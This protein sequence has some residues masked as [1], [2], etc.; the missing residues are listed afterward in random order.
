MNWKW[1]LQFWCGGGM[2]TIQHLSTFIGISVHKMKRDTV[3]FII[4]FSLTSQSADIYHLVAG[5]KWMSYYFAIFEV[6]YQE[7][8]REKS[9]FDPSQKSW[10]SIICS[11]IAIYYLHMRKKLWNQCS[12][13]RIP[14][15]LLH[16]YFIDSVNTDWC[17]KCVCV[18]ARCNIYSM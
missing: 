8:I 3:Q 6:I 16:L 9:E 10:R 1:C 2:K 7:I 13:R 17:G 12:T 4:L 11:S 18:C 15:S 5:G 14:S